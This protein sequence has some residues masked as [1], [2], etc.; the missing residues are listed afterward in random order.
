MRN[1]KL[2]GGIYYGR[3]KQQRI[4]NYGGRSSRKH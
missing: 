1:I 3:I 4:R 2:F